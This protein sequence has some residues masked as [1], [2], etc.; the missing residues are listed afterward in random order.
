MNLRLGKIQATTMT[1]DPE[2]S[3][4]ANVVNTPA[5]IDADALLLGLRRKQGHWVDWGQACQQLQKA[6]YDAQTIFEGTGF[7]P[8]QQNQIMTAAQVYQSLVSQ[9]AGA[10]TLAHFQERGSD[11]LYEFRILNQTQ[12]AKAATFAWQKKLDADVAHDLAKAIQDMHRLSRLPDGFTEAAGDAVAYHAWKAARQ[13][14]DLQERSRLIARGLSFAESDSARKELEKLLT[15]F[16]VINAAVAPRWPIYRPEEGE[17]LPRLVPVAGDWPI[18]RADLQAVPMLEETGAFRLVQHKGG[19]AWL[20]L[21]GWQVLQAAEDPVGILAN[22][23]A[24]EGLT[25]AEGDEAIL[26]IIDRADREWQADAYFLVDAEQTLDFC[27]FSAPPDQRLLGRVILVLR[28]KKVVVESLG[29]DLW[30]F[31]E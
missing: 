7:E 20:A 13:K 24:L 29:S 10:E 4:S 26:V 8:I 6:G 21:P 28:P 23:E 15:D 12:R 22:S 27:F 2:S 14:S 18:S 16:T 31:E 25:F 17:S 5:P 11:V 19:G 30:Q 3:S 1:Q 9:P